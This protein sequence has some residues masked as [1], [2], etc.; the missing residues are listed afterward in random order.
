MAWNPAA[1][2][3]GCASCGGT[4]A[5]ADH[6]APVVLHQIDVAAIPPG[7]PGRDVEVTCAGC[8]ATIPAPADVIAGLCSYCRA[9]FVV[10]SGHGADPLPDGVVAATI[11]IHKAEEAV[12]TWVASRR[13][14]PRHFKS[15]AQRPRITL[16]Y[17]PLFAFNTLTSTTYNG[18]RG[19]NYTVT[20]WVTVPNPNGGSH[21]EA[22]AETRIRW[23]QASGTVAG[24]FQGVAVAAEN[25]P[26]GET[27]SGDW[28][29][30]SAH[31]YRD[32][33]MVGAVAHAATAPV[34]EGW[35]EAKASIAPAIEQLICE[36]IGGDHQRIDQAF[37]N[38]SSSSY[39]YLL[40]PSWSGD[41]EWKGTTYAIEV[42]AETGTASGTRP[43]S[44]VKI[45]L[46]IIAGVL[47][48]AAI[49][50]LVLLLA[51][52]HSH[53][54]AVGLNLRPSLRSP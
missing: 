17:H 22:R 21:Q 10:T 6:G 34:S 51:H 8:G 1:Q 26:E 18:Q 32:D 25:A 14:A 33:Y 24:E 31:S 46:A 13:F 35:E 15:E 48:V 4:V 47:V 37:T 12:G 50:L 2:S 5:V 54:G 38:Y 49:V 43:Y 29:L 19:D 45:A 39:C 20:V 41:Y 52:G 23:S 30:N 53:S 44:A 7:S 11:D 3:M 42:N 36:D 16:G 40:V 27:G 28:D 9:P